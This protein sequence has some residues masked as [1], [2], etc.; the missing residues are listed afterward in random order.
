M[1]S[2]DKHLNASFYFWIIYIQSPAFICSCLRSLI[3]THYVRAFSYFPGMFLFFLGKRL[4]SDING[5]QHYILINACLYTGSSTMSEASAIRLL[6][7]SGEFNFFTLAF[8][9]LPKVTNSDSTSNVS[10]AWKNFLK[11]FL[12]LVWHIFF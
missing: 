3:N 8:K 12:M 9:K 7:A 2:F 1:Y 6:L 10:P 5:L 4:N 11:S